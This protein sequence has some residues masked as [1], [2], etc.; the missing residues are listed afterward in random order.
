[1]RHS[2]SRFVP[3]LCLF[4]AFLLT[5]LAPLAAQT[6][7]V[8]MG[9]RVILTI[10]CIGPLGPSIW[11]SVFSARLVPLPPETYIWTPLTITHTAG[12]PRNPG[13]Q[14]LGL[15][16]SPHFC[17]V[18]TPPLAAYFYGLRLTTIGTSGAF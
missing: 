17:W 15:A 12:P 11:F 13:Q 2:F 4:V 10:P 7:L 1:M 14:V 6:P 8:S 3:A 5:P 18:G 9:G 16:D